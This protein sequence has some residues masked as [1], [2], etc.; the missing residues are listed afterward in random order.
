MVLQPDGCGNASDSTRFDELVPGAPDWG[1]A[2]HPLVRGPH[3]VIGSASH[4]SDY[5][6]IHQR[7]IEPTMVSGD[8]HA[9][10]VRLDFLRDILIELAAALPPDLAAGVAT[11]IGNRLTERLGD[12]EIDEP[13]DDAMVSDLAPPFRCHSRPCTTHV[14]S[15]NRPDNRSQ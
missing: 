14:F 3:R 10:T 9:V 12:A 8:L 5:D 4:T 2:C 13:T 7:A 11:A 15:S 6:R 1:A